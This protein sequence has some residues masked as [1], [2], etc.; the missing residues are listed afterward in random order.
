MPFFGPWSQPSGDVTFERLQPVAPTS[1]D[2]CVF[3]TGII[4]TRPMPLAEAETLFG[5]AVLWNDHRNG[6]SPWGGG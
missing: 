1:E 6:G 5:T 3:G 2:L 4:P